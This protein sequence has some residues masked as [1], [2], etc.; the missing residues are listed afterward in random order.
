MTMKQTLLVAGALSVMALSAPPLQARAESL[1]FAPLSGSVRILQDVPCG[2]R[3]DVT[4]PIAGGRMVITPLMTREGMLLDL[5]RV[6]AFLTPF[7]VERECLGIRASADFFEIGIRLAG[8]VIVPADEAGDGLHR[9]TIPKEKFV[10]YASVS[11]NAPA[12]QPETEFR[13]PA[14]D[15][16]GVIDLRRRTAQL[17][18]ALTAR[19][20]FRAGCVGGRCLID[21]RLEGTQVAEVVAVSPAPGA[22]TDGDRVPDLTDNCPLVSNPTQAPVAT[23]VLIA[24]PDVTLTACRA[25]DIGEATAIDVCHGRPVRITND[26]PARFAIGPNV[27]T[28]SANDGIDPIATA[29]QI[30]T[31]DGTRDTT[32]PTASCSAVDAS[33]HVFQVFADDNCAAPSIR[34]GGY[35]LA[36]GEVV[37]MQRTGRP[38]VRLL[39]TNRAGDSRHFLV[40][41]EDAFITATDAAGNVATALCR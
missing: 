17:R 36:A 7:S 9:F 38:G 29:R 32:P 8:A 23:P 39:D 34:L 11:D 28:W 2:E 1:V 40:G 20:H 25:H 19:L 12:P 37:R 30:V 5:T 27:V 33:G 31:I 14:E 18:V 10:M 16:T 22:D 41:R 24:P 15:I 35:A 13:R 4:T 6:E 26:A 21:Q 3:V